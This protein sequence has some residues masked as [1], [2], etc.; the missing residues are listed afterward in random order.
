MFFSFPFFLSRIVVN[1]QHRMYKEQEE[2]IRNLALSLG[3][4]LN[5]YFATCQIELSKIKPSDLQLSV[6]KIRRNLHEAT[7][8]LDM[9]KAFFY[10]GSVKPNLF[11]IKRAIQNAIEEF[12]TA[13]HYKVSIEG[14]DFL[15]FLDPYLFKLIL[16]NLMKNAFFALKKAGKGDV[17]FLLEKG[18]TTNFLN[19][20]D[21]GCGICHSIKKH[22]FERFFTS[23]SYGT[24]MGLVFCKEVIERFGGD[25]S[26][27]SEEGKGTIFTLSIPGKEN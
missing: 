16:F 11:S 7:L 14:E 8:F 24:G 20:K 26:F 22:I 18:T 10:Q 5:T 25:I 13:T 15:I 3:H 27:V 23:N 2:R 19:I 17:V 1:H 4:E 12:P 9:L 21:T 6:M